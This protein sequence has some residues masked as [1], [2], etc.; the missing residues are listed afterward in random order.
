M[1]DE[2]HEVGPGN[3]GPAGL[4]SEE[5]VAEVVELL[6]TI[7]REL[8]TLRQIEFGFTNDEATRLE[9]A[10]WWAKAIVVVKRDESRDPEVVLTDNYA[11]T[12]MEALALLVTRFRY[13]YIAQ[14]R[15]TG[16][17]LQDNRRPRRPSDETRYTPGSGGKGRLP[18]KVAG[19]HRWV[20]M[21]TFTLTQGQARM[22]GVAGARVNLDEKNRLGVELG[23]IDCEEPYGA[24]KDQRCEG[25]EYEWR[26]PGEPS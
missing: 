12:P 16:E 2:S 4:L 22:A 25:D 10:G 24:V 19:E 20:A 17:L 23:C 6:A 9:D 15:Q 21:A 13:R 5:M 8:P 11:W 14:D 26:Y 1:S 7:E 3:P 18:P